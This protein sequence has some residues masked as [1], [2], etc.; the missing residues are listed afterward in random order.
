MAYYNKIGLLI[1]SEDHKKFLVCQKYAQNVTAD[2]IM[3]GGKNDEGDDYECLH[4]EIKQELDCEVD[5][6]TLEY[7]GTYEDIAAGRPGRTVEIKLYQGNIIGN[8][9]PSEEV[10]FIHYIDKEALNNTRVSPIIRTK[11]LPDLLARGIV[12][13]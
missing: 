9:K 8:P 7:I 1:L 5:F 4:N 10:E 13:S 12:K 11:I 6:D 2:Y 3:P